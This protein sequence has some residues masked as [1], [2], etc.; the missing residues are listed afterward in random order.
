MREDRL[1]GL[2]RRTLR[3]LPRGFRE[4]RGEDLARLF[5]TLVTDARRRGG[6]ATAVACLVRESADVLMTAVQ[7][8]MRGRETEGGGAMDKLGLDLWRYDLRLAVRGLGRSPGFVAVVV[9][10]LG[11]GIGATTAI[12]SV[13]NGVL[14][15]PLPFHEAERLALVWENDRETGSVREAGSWPDYLDIRER[16][17]AFSDVAAFGSRS[18]NLTRADADPTRVRMTAVTDNLDAVLGVSPAL[19]RGIRAEEA[20][21]GGGLVAVLTDGFWARGFGRDPEVLGQL[22]SIDDETYTIVGALPSGLEYPEETTDLWAPLQ[23]DAE[24]APRWTHPYTMVGRLAPGVSVD[25]AQAEASAIMADLEATFPENEARGAFVEPIEDVIRGNVSTPLMI[26]FGAVFLVL[27]VACANVANLFLARGAQRTTE[28]AVTAALGASAGRMARRFLVESLL[29]TGAAAVVGVVL[30]F[31]GA[32]TIMA[33]APVEVSSLGRVTLDSDVLAF[34]VLTTLAVGVLFA[35]VPARQ[36]YNVDLQGALKEG[37]SQGGAGGLDKLRAR[38]VLV[39]SQMALAMVLLVGAGLL[40]HSLWKIQQI[41]PG[42][43]TEGILRA[44]FQLPSS[45]YPRDFSVYPRWA[46]VHAFNQALTE[47]ARGL[48]GVQAAAIVSQHSLDPGFTNSFL[49]VGREAES[50]DWGELVTRLVGPAYFATTGLRVVEGRA[51]D[52][53]DDAEAPLVALVNRATVERY[54]PDHPVIGS[55]IRFWGMAREIVGIVEDEK[56]YG[57]TTETPPAVYASMKQA[58]QTGRATLMVRTTGDP[59]SLADPIRAAVAELDADIPVYNV[60]TMD[61]TLAD[62]LARERFTSLLLAVF[63]GVGLLIALI[64]VHGVLSYLV[65]QRG[66]EVGVRMALGASRGQVRRMVV[67][68]GMGLAVA[69]IAL[70]LAAALGVSRLLGG[71]LYGVSPTEPFTYAAVAGVL[72]VAALVAS[73]LPARR[74]TR[75]DPVEALRS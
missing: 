3:A 30:A 10:T 6:G 1:T 46:E 68:Q 36:A 57:L 32:R 63:A 35:L 8:R 51:F 5:E 19:G 41:D 69:G 62:S 45:R 71:L 73:A 31:A 16:T 4:R 9:V 66:H 55:Q 29:L 23:T 13:V 40:I 60:A 21:P 22:L 12:F 25:A 74:A 37:R 52:E 53:S 34:T 44:E 65:A 2:Y 14:L 56:M 47:R 17:R 58:P 59:L 49:V 28:L 38:R 11:L 75:I 15:R 54:F 72:A 43:R 26:L 70:G 27:L 20:R 39:V 42:F 33:A 48:P 18:A 61:Q 64:G 67:S 50:A 7:L 24:L